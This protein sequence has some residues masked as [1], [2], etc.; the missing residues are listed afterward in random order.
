QSCAFIKSFWRI[1][2]AGRWPD[3]SW[4]TRGSRLIQ[5]MSPRSGMYDTLVIPTLGAHILTPVKLP[6][7][8]LRR[9]TLKQHFQG[10]ALWCPNRRKHNRLALKGHSKFLVYGYICGLQNLL[11]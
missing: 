7:Y 9:D 8:I 1:T 10:Y 4:P 2:I 6:M 11:G 5:I 3:C